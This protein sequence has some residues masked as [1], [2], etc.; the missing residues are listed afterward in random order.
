MSQPIFVNTNTTAIVCKSDRPMNGDPE[1][2]RKKKNPQL[3][4]SFTKCYL[5]N[6]N[7]IQYSDGQYVLRGIGFVM[8][9]GINI[10]LK[11]DLFIYY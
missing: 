5:V 9:G 6:M 11:E 7:G 3:Q 10:L 4:A 8:G 1:K 2:K